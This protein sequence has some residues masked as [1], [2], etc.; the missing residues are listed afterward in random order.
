MPVASVPVAELL[1]Q[2]RQEC[3]QAN[4][5]SP[6]DLPHIELHS[7]YVWNHMLLKTGAVVMCRSAANIAEAIIN[8]AYAVMVS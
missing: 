7:R 4:R 6:T 8:K 3:E 2:S 5:R 1:Q